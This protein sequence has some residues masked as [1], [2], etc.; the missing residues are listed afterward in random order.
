[1][2]F[3]GRDTTGWRFAGHVKRNHWTVGA[4]SLD[5][6]DP[7]KLVAAPGGSDLVSP[8]IVGANIVTEQSFGDAV[9][10]LDVMIPAESNSGIFVMGEYEV[11]VLDDPAAKADAPTN[12]DSGAIVGVSPPRTLVPLKA[13]AWH[14]YVIDFAAPRFDAAGKKIAEARFMRISIDGQVVQENV[15]VAE[16]TPSNLTGEEHPTGPLM[17][18]GAEGPVAYRNIVVTPR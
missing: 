3:N 5:P 6:A 7:K 15:T 2:P 17:L 4:A 16:P 13:G 18:Q 11:Q 9:I 10:E 8:G 12:M 14:H 1:M